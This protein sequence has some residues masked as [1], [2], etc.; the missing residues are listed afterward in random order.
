MDLNIDSVRA[1]LAARN[2]KTMPTIEDLAAELGA[3]GRELTELIKIIDNMVVTGEITVT[4]KGRIARPE[5]QG[6]Y[7]GKIQMHAKGFGFLIRESEKDKKTRKDIFIPPDSTMNAMN[8]DTVMVKLKNYVRPTDERLEGEVVKILKRNTST[9]IGVYRESEKY[10]FVVPEDRKIKDDIYVR[11]EDSLNAKTNDVVVAEIVKYSTDSK[12]AEGKVISVLG[13]KGDPGVDMLTILSKY[14]L[15][16]EFPEKVI[17]YTDNIPS[18]ITPEEL[19]KRR[20]LT[21]ETIVTIDGADAKDLD[22]AVTVE[23]LPNGNYKLGVHIADVTHYVREGSILDEEALKRATSVYLLDL[24]IPMLPRRLSND[25]CS[26]NPDTLKLTLSCVMEI[27][28]QGAVKEYDIFESYIRTAARMTYDDVTKIL[29]GDEETSEKYKN[30]VP[31][32]KNMEE[33][34]RILRKKREDRGAIDFDF[35]ESYIELDGE[36]NPIDV[37]PAVRGVSNRIIEEFMLAANECVAE[38]MSWQRIPFVY[39]IHENPDPEK[40]ATFALM[41]SSMGY[42]IRIGKDIVPRHLQEILSRVKGTDAEQVL[43]GLLLRSMMQAKYSPNNLGHFGLAAEYYCHFTSPIRRYPDL[44]IHRIIKKQLKGE[45]AGKEIERYQAIVEK[46]SI[47][48][49]EMERV[50]QDAEREV[51]DLK[52]AQYMHSKLG[53]EFDGIISSVTNFG[54]FVELP[55]T[56]EGLVHTTEMPGDYI[57]DEN[58]MVLSSTTGGTDFKLGDKVR[59]KVA[60]VDVDARQINFA[61]LGRVDKEGDVFEA[62]DR[63]KAEPIVVGNFSREQTGRRNRKG[64]EGKSNDKNRSKSK[65]R[66]RDKKGFGEKSPESRSFSKS[67]SRRDKRK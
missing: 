10:G 19:E 21:G 56:I 14:A 28:A 12:A 39:R 42:P 62:Y 1:Y 40:L 3:E 24:V 8:G 34:Y 60:S 46:A 6:F 7:A 2:G 59:I 31:L 22:D 44:Q 17:E 65:S 45:M 18:E 48:S 23:K 20:D 63:Q 26:L 5:D 58:R 67:R 9:V 52:K 51:D 32:F 36:G 55:N 66:S 33:L 30:L 41:A 27:D 54:F 16:A 49:S 38:S 64:N 4:K 13:R 47:I 29:D 25:L 15:P 57:Y 53:E 35:T 61:F 50:A 11:K 43:S 37:R